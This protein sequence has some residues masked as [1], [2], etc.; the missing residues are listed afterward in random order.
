MYMEAMAAGAILSEH[1]GRVMSLDFNGSGELML[2]TG[3]DDRLCV[4]SCQS[5]QL[6]RAVQSPR[7][8]VG[9]AR[10]THD[11]L[12]VICASRAGEA[13]AASGAAGAAGGAAGGGG[14]AHAIRY[15][16]L[17]DN[18]YLRFF[19]GHTAPVLSLS[20]SPKDDVFASAAA[21]ETMRTWDLRVPGCLGVLR[22]PGSGRRP[23]VSF[24]PEGLVLAAGVGGNQVK[25][26][27]LRF[28]SKGP[29]AT[30]SVPGEPRDFASICFNFDGKLMLVGTAQGAAVSID[31]FKGTELQTFRGHA[32]KM[33]L[34]LEACFSADGAQVMSGS[35]DGKIW[36]WRT[37]DASLVAAQAGHRG[38]VTS[39]KCNPT[40]QLVASAGEEVCLWLPA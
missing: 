5:G 23:A 7:Y 29:F 20:V 32:N 36:R 1:K 27:D 10:F 17:H 2:S 6:Q 4:Y 28:A 34:P 22:F 19:T 15:H 35:E 16:S 31:A 18:T 9:I 11:P 39:V 37:H 40:R 13:G 24:D 30:F 25:L 26:F 33:G 14:G 38:P 21:D 12:S 8:G 3:E